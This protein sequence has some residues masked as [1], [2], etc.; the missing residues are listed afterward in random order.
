M[1][2][3]ISITTAGACFLGLVA[4]IFA[5]ADMPSAV[6]ASYMTAEEQAI[7]YIAASSH[8]AHMELARRA[9]EDG[10]LELA[11]RH[12]HI[13]YKAEFNSIDAA[14]AI[15]RVT[16][17]YAAELI[18][19]G[20]HIKAVN[21]INDAANVLVTLRNVLEHPD[22]DPRPLEPLLQLEQELRQT[23]RRIQAHA[24]EMMVEHL[25]SAEQSYRDAGRWYWSN[26]RDEVRNGL[27]ALRPVQDRLDIVD[28]D[29]RAEFFRVLDLLKS[30]VSDKEW[31]ALLASAGIE[32]DLLHGNHGIM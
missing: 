26:R 18:A 16:A 8:D 1:K 23:Y 4:S 6:N 5:T 27:R 32:L 31:D 3:L 12:L 22:A 14:S 10:R 13:A 17:D 21:A 28:R 11:L 2:S 24:S 9:V 30:R 29:T 19:E 7:E 15:V 20:E 25:R